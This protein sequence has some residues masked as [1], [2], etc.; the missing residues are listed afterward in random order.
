LATPER[1][2]GPEVD[3][4]G[5]RTA[6]LFDRHGRTVLALCRTLLR[7]PHEAEDAAQQTYLS[8]Y[9]SLL[10]GTEPRDARAWL[11]TI[12]RNECRSRIRRRRAVT[13]VP[14]D[15][16]TATESWAPELSDV[17]QERA[18]VAELRAAIADL[19]ERQREA[20]V[21]RDFYGLSYEE[22]GAALSASP[23]AVESLLQ[24]GRKRIQTRVRSGRVAS[25]AL[26]LPDGLRDEL[27]RLIPGFGTTM[28]P[29]A[30]AAGAGG[31]AL[32][33]LLSVP[34][35]AKITAATGVVAVGIGVGV[36]T[37]HPRPR[38]ESTRPPPAKLADETPRRAVAA[39]RAPVEERAQERRPADDSG[40]ADDSGGRVAPVAAPQDRSGP[41]RGSRREED[42]GDDVEVPERDE[43]PVVP[44]APTVD[45]SGPGPADD[46]DEEQAEVSNRGPGSSSSGPSTSGSSG[47]GSSGEADGDDVS[48]DSGP[49]SSGVSDDSGS[50]SSGVSDDSGSGS[51]ASGSGSDDPAEPEDED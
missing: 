26:T 32:F 5:R 50:G 17:A 43:E 16:A 36:A 37:K 45:A 3:A 46:D 4:V 51:S 27:A 30:A 47:S 14:V 15:D 39:A 29:E 24:R 22:V 2:Q 23:P 19:P 31:A 9:R 44:P 7:D 21:L 34:A 6:L 1:A 25:G 10:A 28:A 42:G 49:G 35:A 12:A 40:R 13:Q 18:D 8:A 11:A 20:V 48:D 41:N 33:K 38:D